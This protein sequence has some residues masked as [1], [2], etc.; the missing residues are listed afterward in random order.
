MVYYFLPISLPPLIYFILIRPQLG[1]NIGSSARAL[2]NFNFNKLRIVKPRDGWPN[3]DAIA[4][5]SGADTVI[6]NA[7]IYNT[8][9]VSSI[10]W[11]DSQKNNS[12]IFKSNYLYKLIIFYL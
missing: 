4:A 11:E 10:N 3:N 6:E 9:I 2:K 12:Q 8:T 5:S 7:K 1:E